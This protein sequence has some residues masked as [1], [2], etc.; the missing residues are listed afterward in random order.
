[1]P[2]GRRVSFL[3]PL[4]LRPPPSPARPTLTCL[5][6]A[7]AVEPRRAVST[8]ATAHSNS[9]SLCHLAI[10][11]ISVK[12]SRLTSSRSIFHIYYALIVAPSICYCSCC[13]YQEYSQRHCVLPLSF[14]WFLLVF[15]LLAMLGGLVVQ[16]GW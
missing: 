6:C 14:R 4:L 7:F 9:I 12:F 1:M 5:I 15:K 13:R 3:A 11:A 10:V 8:A 2:L 16:R